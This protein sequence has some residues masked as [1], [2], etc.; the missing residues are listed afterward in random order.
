MSYNCYLDDIL[1]RE[2]KCVTTYSYEPVVNHQPKMKPESTSK[3]VP[4]SCQFRH[5]CTFKSFHHLIESGACL[6][7]GVVWEPASDI[8]SY[9]PSC[10]ESVCGDRITIEVIRNNGLHYMKVKMVWAVL[11]AATNFEAIGS[12]IIGEELNG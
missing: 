10:A 5:S 12:E 3:A 2:V 11:M 6:F 1:E 9:I 8:R 4:S 7:F